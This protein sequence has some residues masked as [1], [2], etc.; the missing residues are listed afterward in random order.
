MSRTQSSFP[1][2]PAAPCRPRWW[3]PTS[4]ARSA[5]SK[6]SCVQR[7][8]STSLPGLP[9]T[10]SIQAAEEMNSPRGDAL[11]TAHVVPIGRAWTDV[12]DARFRIG[13][14]R[15]RRIT[16]ASVRLVVSSSDLDPFLAVFLMAAPCLR[17]PENSLGA[18]RTATS[19]FNRSRECVGQTDDD[20]QVEVLA[21]ESRSGHVGTES[22]GRRGNAG[23][24]A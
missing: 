5:T 18:T 6:S 15:S 1:R 16:S 12:P 7:S 13:R 17:N 19:N 23:S 14:R 20:L 2:P 3:A 22:C 21:D 24:E 8:F 4:R 11:R 10:S 9:G